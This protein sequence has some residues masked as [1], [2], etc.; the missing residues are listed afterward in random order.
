MPNPYYFFFSYASANYT[1]AK[2]ES[3]GTCGNYL[4]EFFDALCREVSDIAMLPADQVAYRD[5]RRLGVGDFWSQE[6]VQGLQKSR[7]LLALISPNYL[8]SHN[9][10]KELGFFNT[11]IQQLIRNTGADI[12]QHNRILPLFW[13]DSEICFKNAPPGVGKFLQHYNFTQKGMP[14][15]YPAVGLSQICKLRSGTDY[16]Q[17]CRSIAKRIVELADSPDK[18]PELPGLHEFTDIE[19]L[20]SELTSDS[21][22]DLILN[23]PTGANLVYVVGTRSEMQNAG[24]MTV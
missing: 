20:Y 23:G 22:E 8:N 19:S 12:H 2:W 9:C 18:L 5:R 1:N 17:I 24:V 13:E 6:L 11:R 4:D 21:G 16:E 15:N 7:I 10:G 14:A 3:R